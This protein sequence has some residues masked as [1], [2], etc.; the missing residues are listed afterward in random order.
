MRS[1]PESAARATIV[2][3]PAEIRAA[4]LD[5]CGPIQ[6]QIRHSR[7]RLSLLGVRP[8]TIREFYGPILPQ[9][10]HRRS[11]LTPWELRGRDTGQGLVLRLVLPHRVNL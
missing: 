7:S 1:V 4:I 5:F 10:R 8:A 3:N 6:P 9:V 2:A 11:W